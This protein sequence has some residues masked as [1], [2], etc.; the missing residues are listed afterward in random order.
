MIF[1]SKSEIIQRHLYRH[2]SQTSF[3]DHENSIPR[4]EQPNSKRTTTS[5]NVK[6]TTVVYEYTLPQ[7]G[8][9]QLLLHWLQPSLTRTRPEVEGV[10]T[11]KGYTQTQTQEWTETVGS[12]CLVRN[13]G[14][15]TPNFLIPSLS[16]LTPKK[17]LTLVSF[18]CITHQ[19][20]TPNRNLENV[21]ST[22]TA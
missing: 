4:P 10:S 20:C 6:R 3:R 12:I 17:T 21:N 11:I 13:E 7:G 19:F 16:A 2:V 14:G 18:L 15:K 1:K 22:D 9:S 5:G 8:N